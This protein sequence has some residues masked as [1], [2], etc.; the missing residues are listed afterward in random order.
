MAKLNNAP[1]PSL[2]CRIT[3]LLKRYPSGLRRDALNRKLGR[4]T[5]LQDIDAS[6]KCL[7]SIGVITCSEGR[8]WIR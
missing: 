4:K 5:S 1:I 7:L 6:L 2:E 8:W 3:T